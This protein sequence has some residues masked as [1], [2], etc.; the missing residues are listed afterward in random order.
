MMSEFWKWVASAF[1]VAAALA[2]MF[3][4]LSSGLALEI[5]AKALLAWTVATVLVCLVI[6]VKG[7]I[8]D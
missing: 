3:L 4:W 2:L 6:V 1:T 8:F 7:C 5:G